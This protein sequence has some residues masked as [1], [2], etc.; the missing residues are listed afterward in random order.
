MPGLVCTHDIKL[1]GDFVASTT[2]Q[3]GLYVAK[4]VLLTR[5]SIN[6]SRNNRSEQK[7]Y[8]IFGVNLETESFMPG[9]RGLCPHCALL[10][11]QQFKIIFFIPLARQPVAQPSNSSSMNST[12]RSRR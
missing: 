2:R 7:S 5:P 4:R 9:A 10:A 11:L 3:N 6:F 8:S 12:A 1:Y